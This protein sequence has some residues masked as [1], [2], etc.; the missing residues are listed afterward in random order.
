MAR[1]WYPEKRNAKSRRWRFW[2][3]GADLDEDGCLRIYRQPSG[4]SKAGNRCLKLHQMDTD[5][6]P[7]A[8]DI[9]QETT[10]GPAIT[11]R[12]NANEADTTGG[13]ISRD[14]VVTT[15]SSVES[16]ENFKGIKDAT[17]EKIVKNLEIKSWQYKESDGERSVGPTAEDFKK[18]TGYGDGRRINQ[19]TLLGLTFRVVQLLYKKLTT[20]EARLDLLDSRLEDWA[21]RQG[22]PPPS[23]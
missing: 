15:R 19:M 10:S 8:L 11:F 16:K 14:G 13:S 5:T 6:D 22:E 3:L 4:A 7:T 9:V 17:A 20:L 1:T 2:I 18:V 23:E 12:R 21:E